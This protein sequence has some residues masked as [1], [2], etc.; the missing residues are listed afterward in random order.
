MLALLAPSTRPRWQR[1]AL[2]GYRDD[3]PPA[4]FQ[5]SGGGEGGGRQASVTLSA[6]PRALESAMASRD[7]LV[8]AQAQQLAQSLAWPGRYTAAPKPR[9]L[10]PAEQAR[11]ASGERQYAGTCAGCHQARGTGLAG[12]AKP[13][14]GSPW[15]LGRPEQ[16]IRI[17]LH[18]KEGEMLMPPLGG[19]LTNE[20]IANVLTYVRRSWGN[21][22]APIT[23]AEVA[24]VRG[25]TTGRAKPWTEAELKGVGR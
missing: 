24:E 14:V 23:P 1:L 3:A 19:A 17:V 22:A 8:R 5:Y 15:A 4:R 21:A 9:A 11:Y 20:Q 10:T 13:L 18:G 12:V 16:L 2:L 25:A 7:T 6:A